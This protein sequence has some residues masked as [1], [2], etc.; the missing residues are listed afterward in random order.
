MHLLKPLVIAA[1]QCAAEH[2]IAVSAWC[3]GLGRKSLAQ[4]MLEIANKDASD[5]CDKGLLQAMVKQRQ[6]LLHHLQ[7]MFSLWLWG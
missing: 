2:G 3:F 4:C 7:V 6:H 1:A 5:L